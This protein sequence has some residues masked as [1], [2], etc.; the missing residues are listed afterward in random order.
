MTYVVGLTG[1]IG[2]GKST[3]AELFRR[4]G[5]AVI[6]TDEIAHALTRPGAEGFAAI[7]RAFGPEMLDAQGRLDR[8]RLRRLVFADADARKKL[9]DILHP[10]IRAEVARKL[11][12]APGPYVVVVVP[13]LIETG[14][15]RELVNRVLVVDCPEETQIQRTMARS[16]LT[17]PEVVAIM[18]AQAPRARRLACADDVLD[19]SGEPTALEEGVARLDAQ[20]RRLAAAT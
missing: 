2:S 3:V 7:V 16:G 19:N 4:R 11:A 8:A 17:R 1:G 14:G 20:Y 12:T 15:F 18:A 10:L 5:V 13:L 9:E 6:D